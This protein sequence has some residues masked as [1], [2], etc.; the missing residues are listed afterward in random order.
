[1]KEKPDLWTPEGVFV[2]YGKGYI[3]SAGLQTGCSGLVGNDGKPLETSPDGR[4]GVT[5]PSLNGNI[6]TPD[7]QA[8]NTEVLLQQ[9][10]KGGRPHKRDGEPVSRMTKW[11][12]EKEAMQGVLL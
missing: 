10:N 9:K 7:I 2:H 12:R 11:R 3:L 5:K 1:M 6:S 8:Q 4:E